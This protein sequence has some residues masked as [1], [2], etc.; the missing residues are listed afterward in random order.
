MAAR[1]GTPTGEAPA[2]EARMA[3]DA[4]RIAEEQ[5]ALRRVAVLVARA[6]PPEEVFAAVAAE[7]GRL[8]HPSHAAV[9]R[10][11]PD[12]ATSIVGTWSGTAV[13]AVPL[14]TRVSPGDRTVTALVTRTG[15]PARLDD[16]G[17]ATGTAAKIAREYGFRSAVGV[18]VSVA[19]RL[20]GI[21]G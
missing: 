20:G 15:R 13:V 4:R 7:A 17:G 12:G 11:D 1:P 19:G 16:Y 18:P 6:A 3:G 5:A 8:L 2:R 14:G 9:S 21:I 10:Y